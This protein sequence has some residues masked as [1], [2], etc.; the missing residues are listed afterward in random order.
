MVFGGFVSANLAWKALAG[1]GCSV[2]GIQCQQN[3]R[4]RGGTEP[5]PIDPIPAGQAFAVLDGPVSSK[6]AHASIQ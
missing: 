2:R 6:R 3:K 4:I 1:T 5:V